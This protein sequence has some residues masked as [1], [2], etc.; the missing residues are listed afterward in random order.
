M[1]LP[2]YLV[3]PDDFHIFELDESNYCY[4]SYEQYPREHR[5]SAY[6]HFTFQNLSEN[7]GFIPIDEE[8]IPYWEEKH[9]LYLDFMVWSCRPDGHGGRKGGTMEEFLQRRQFLAK[10]KTNGNL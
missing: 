2:K 6:D 10:L 4:R 9:Q 8:D 5:Q 7:Y 1:D 3:R